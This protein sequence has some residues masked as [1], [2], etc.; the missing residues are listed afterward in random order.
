MREKPGLSNQQDI[1]RDRSSSPLY[2]IPKEEITPLKLIGSGFF[3]IVQ[4]ISWN[5]DGDTKICACKTLHD[6]T[7]AHIL[8]EELHNMI[9]LKDDNV[10]KLLGISID[11]KTMS[12]TSIHTE[13]YYGKCLVMAHC[14]V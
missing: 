5:N 1:S 3:G 13:L 7:K 6:L 8:M 11:G 10:V 14:P 9:Q 2:I 12:L 4:K